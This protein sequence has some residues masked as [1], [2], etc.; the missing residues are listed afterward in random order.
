MKVLLD[1]NA[2]TALKRGHASV[3]SL[4]REAEQV[5]LSAIVA[6]ELIYGFR[7]G[8][9]F[10]ANM[11]ELDEFLICPFVSLMPVTLDTAQRFGRIAA[12]LRKKGT[13]VPTNDIWI[14][15]HGF[16]TGAE[17]IS[18]DR[19]FGVIENLAWTCPEEPALPYK[20]SAR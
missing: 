10:E 15:A 13:P 7:H 16:E 19:H 14:A 12:S 2:Y 4:V 11:R 20:K 6:G 9:R 17:L 5:I 1:T 8:S 3:A 18:F